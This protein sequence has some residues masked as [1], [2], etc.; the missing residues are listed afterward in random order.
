MPMTSRLN[1]TRLIP[2]CLAAT[3]FVVAFTVSAWQGHLLSRPQ[4]RTAAG[5]GP[6]A[7]ATTHRR[8]RSSGLPATEAA[9]PEEAAAR[10]M[11]PPAGDPA[12][13]APDAGEQVIDDSP[14]VD[15][16]PERPAP[17]PQPD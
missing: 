14:V 10:F 6:A 15:D 3:G 11:P 9:P 1:P 5:A 2:W 4:P 12:A 8:F 13:P 17:D 16:L 7:M